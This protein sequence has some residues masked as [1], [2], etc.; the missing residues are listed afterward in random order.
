MNGILMKILGSLKYFLVFC[1]L[2]D[3]KLNQTIQNPVTQINKNNQI[4]QNSE[5]QVNQINHMNQINQ[6]AIVNKLPKIV[7]QIN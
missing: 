6:K 5:N 4:N 1:I 2:K 3:I 7:S